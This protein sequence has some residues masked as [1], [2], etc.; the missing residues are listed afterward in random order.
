MV[1][2]M[3]GQANAEGKQISPT[4]AG[5]VQ[6]LSSAKSQ[7]APTIPPAGIQ[8]KAPGGLAVPAMQAEHMQKL[9]D[10]EAYDSTSKDYEALL[11]TCQ[12]TEIKPEVFLA[13]YVA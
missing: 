9:F 11:K 12:R 10:R 3:L 7:A 13:E 4:L 1:I 8:E 5:L 6:R 2:E